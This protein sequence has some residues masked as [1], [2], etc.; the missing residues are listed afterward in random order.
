[1][2]KIEKITYGFHIRA[3]LFEGVFGGLLWSAPEIAR[4]AL[5]VDNLLLTLIVM[6]PAVA[7]GAVLFFGGWISRTGPRR[8][9]RRAATVG[10][11]PLS[12]MILLLVPVI[13]NWAETDQ[14]REIVPWIFLLL[15][16][17]QALASVPITSAW[18]GVIRSNYRDENRGFL[19]GKAQRWGAL[20]SGAGSVIAGYWLHYQSEAFPI[21]YAVAGL[22]G[23]L[24]CM[25][26]SKTPLRDQDKAAPDAPEIN[27]AKALWRLLVRDRR[28]LI[29]EIGFILYGT[30]FMALI[31]AKPMYTVDEEFLGLDWRILLG[32]KGLASLAMVLLTPFYG[33]TLD[34]IGPGWLAGGCY[35]GLALYA[36]LLMAANSA[37]T[38]LLAELVFGISMAGVILA[39]NIGPVSFARADEGRQYMAVHVAL[40]AVRGLIGHPIGG[41]L[42][43]WT[44]DP[45]V[46]FAFSLILWIL[47]AVVMFS[48]GRGPARQENKIESS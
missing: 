33:K 18:N 4:K 41:L 12:L 27:N 47:S 10:R 36:I 28:F 32:A 3:V 23:W 26:F 15:V 8:L 21:L 22:F 40:V 1:M 42:A 43:D 30:A 44:G 25:I 2:P 19:F 20:V 48:L 9:L 6:A 14:G 31:T 38:F 24:S 13:S 16:T 37:M 29:Y 7:Q 46:V 34:R 45:K 11:L 35:C 39:W 17:I 5:G